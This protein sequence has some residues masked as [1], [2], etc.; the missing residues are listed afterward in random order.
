M[1]G[2]EAAVQQHY[3]RGQLTDRILSA[4]RDAGFDP[5]SL[6]YNDL[7]RL[8]QFHTRGRDATLDLARLAEVREGASVLDIGSGIGG[9]ARLLAAEL[10]CR[11]IG[12]DLTAEF[13][14]TAGALSRLVNVPVEFRQANA[15]DLPFPAEEF[16]VV[17]TQHASM[18]VE[19]K[20]RMFAEALRVLKPGGRLAL[21]DVVAGEGGPLHFPVP[22]A[23][24]PGFSFLIP[25]ESM[26][27]KLQSAGFR[28]LHFEEGTQEALEWFQKRVADG[29]TKLSLQVVMG[30][31]FATM[32]VNQIRNLAEG[33]AGMLRAVAEK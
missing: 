2:I 25:A 24:H 10:G 16:D 22:W 14:E 26:R 28:V 7:A 5:A 21:Y 1:P 32:V 8:D 17:W 20:D 11:V 23:T 6:A 29:P 27:E 18:N 4:F 12:I 15:L 3:S 19:D 33:R 30:A 9:P 13:C 31:E